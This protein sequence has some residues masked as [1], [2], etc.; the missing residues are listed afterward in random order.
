[1]DPAL[2]S[3]APRALQKAGCRGHRMTSGAGH[4]A[5]VLAEKIPSVMIFLRSPG[6]LSHQPEESVW[7]SPPPP[8]TGIF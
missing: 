1:M 7:C 5:M 6:G 8:Q 3:A 4:D 2:V